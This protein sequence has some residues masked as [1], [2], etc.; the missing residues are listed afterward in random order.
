M[1]EGGRRHIRPERWEGRRVRGSAISRKEQGWSRQSC[2]RAGGRVWRKLP[3]W[4]GRQVADWLRGWPPQEASQGGH[5]GFTT[6]EMGPARRAGGGGG[7]G[8]GRPFQGP[9]QGLCPGPHVSSPVQGGGPAM[10]SGP[11]QVPE[12]EMLP[13]PVPPWDRY[14]IP[15]PGILLSPPSPPTHQPL[16]RLSSLSPGTLP[17]CHHS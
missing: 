10:V 9:H 8:L 3:G 15:Q 7:K 4:A 14:L 17:T 5:R 1:N 12:Q 6:Q 13:T 2:N 16:P 11:G